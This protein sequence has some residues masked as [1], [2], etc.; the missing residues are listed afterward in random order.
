M[1]SRLLLRFISSRRP[2]GRLVDSVSVVVLPSCLNASFALFFLEILPDSQ[3]Y[4]GHGECG[5]VGGRPSGK[6]NLLVIFINM[7][8]ICLLQRN[9]LSV[10]G[11]SPLKNNPT[12]DS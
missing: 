6:K 8:H 1:R 9:N 3:P 2:N 7:S 5:E 10:V 4:V 12:A 11:I